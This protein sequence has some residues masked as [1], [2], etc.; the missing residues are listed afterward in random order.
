MSRLRRIL[1][2]VGVV[3][4]LFLPGIARVG[5]RQDHPTPLR[6]VHVVKPGET[7]WGIARALAPDR[8][9][10]VTVD[11][12]IAVNRLRGAALRPGQPL[13]LPYS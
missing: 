13:F 11:R 7:L 2:I 10:L 9:V 4:A 8:D 6:L 1:V 3:A 5:A 12:L